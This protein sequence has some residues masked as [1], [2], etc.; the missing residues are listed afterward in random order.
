[1]TRKTRRILCAIGGGL[2]GLVIL[3][4]FVLRMIAAVQSGHGAD[5]YT[6]MKGIKTT[7]I[8]V[9]VLLAVVPIVLVVAYALEWFQRRRNLSDRG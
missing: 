2:L 6:S 3:I 7:P 9:L 8:S 5:I 1:M 4:G